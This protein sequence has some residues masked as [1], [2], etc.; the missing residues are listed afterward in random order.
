MGQMPVPRFAREFTSPHCIA[1]EMLDLRGQS[2][3][4]H[5][6]SQ[7]PHCH[8]R[9]AGGFWMIGQSRQVEKSIVPKNILHDAVATGRRPERQMRL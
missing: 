4:A 2:R 1:D 5:D 6:A 3:I 8:V 7:P 9:F